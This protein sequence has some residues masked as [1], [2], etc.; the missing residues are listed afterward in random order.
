VIITAE[1]KRFYDTAEIC[2]NGHV[3]TLH[4]ESLPIERKSYCP[5]CN[6]A[7]I[8]ECPTCR[9]K[10]QGCYHVGKRTLTSFNCFEPG[11][12]QYSYHTYCITQPEQY[13]LPAYCYHCGKPFPW[14]DALISEAD[15][16]IEMMSDLKPDQKKELKSIFPDLIA[17]TS[18]TVS[19]SIKAG[20][21][22]KSVDK[23]LVDALKAQVGSSI[24]ATAAKFLNW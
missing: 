2:K 13:V 10:I 7:T 4:Y 24:V 21:I 11:Q 23:F 5:L 18:S 17:D 15:K 3:I 16:I 12:E 20:S 19:S 1:V 8:H 6:A 14:T 22:L 9:E